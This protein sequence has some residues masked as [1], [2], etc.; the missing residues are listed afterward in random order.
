M[1]KKSADVENKGTAVSNKDMAVAAAAGN[2]DIAA[3]DK[4]AADIYRRLRW[5]AS[6]L[7]CAVAQD[8]LNG[9]VLMVAWMDETAL[10]RTLRTGRVWYWSRSR[11]E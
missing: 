4:L 6:G 3:E 10:A 1:S 9:E 2:K 5:D 8:Y 7:I 11:Q